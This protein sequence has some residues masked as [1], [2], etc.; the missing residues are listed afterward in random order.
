[1]S[2][3]GKKKNVDNEQT[4]ELNDLMNTTLEF[5]QQTGTWTEL[6]T[7]SYQKHQNKL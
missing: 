4:R 3:F 1:M 5:D 6:P 7:M 2:F